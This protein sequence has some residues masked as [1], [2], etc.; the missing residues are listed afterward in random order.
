MQSS[1]PYFCRTKQHD[2]RSTTCCTTNKT[3]SFQVWFM[4]ALILKWFMLCLS[5]FYLRSSSFGWFL[6]SRLRSMRSDS[7]CFRTSVAYS[8]RPCSAVMMSEATLPRSLMEKDRWVSSVRMKVSRNTL[9]LMS[10]PN[11]FKAFSTFCWPL[12]DT[13]RK[14][15]AS[16]WLFCWL[17]LEKL[18]SLLHRDQPCVILMFL[19]RQTEVCAHTE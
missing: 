10:C 3:S 6:L 15:H 17:R 7:R 14:V 16:S 4:F 13:W 2:I 11:N 9:L 18:L 8:S 1:N 12:P 5:V 19:T